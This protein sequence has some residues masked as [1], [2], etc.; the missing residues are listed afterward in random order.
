MIQLKTVAVEAAGLSYSTPLGRPLQRNLN[1]S[2]TSGQM[3]L[4]RGANGCGKSTLLKNLMGESSKY[5][6]KLQ[7]AVNKD[8]T[9]YIPQLE[10]TEI[11]FPLTLRDVLEIASPKARDVSSALGFG[12]V[13]PQH[14]SAAW[15]TASG[16]E[17]KRVLLTRALM[18]K[19][20]LLVLDEPMNH[21]DSDSRQAMVRAMGNFLNDPG[22]GL[23]AIVMVC[24]QGLKQEEEALIDF[25]TLDLDKERSK[26]KLDVGT[27]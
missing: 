11:H 24:H 19:P 22:H 12:L 25:V 26:E 14:L 5:Q 4:I 6:G 27:A 16:G 8:D 15:N 13:Q 9:Q 7:C 18:R 20:K 2:I 1:F 21:L 3:L 10:N 23:R 17:R